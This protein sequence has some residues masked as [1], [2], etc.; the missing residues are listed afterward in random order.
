VTCTAASL[1]NAAVLTVSMV[2]DVT[3]GSGR[4]VTDTASVS[5]LVFDGTT[6]N[7]SSTVGTRVN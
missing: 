7:N 3:Y 2:V 6:T 1:A 5:S 4:T